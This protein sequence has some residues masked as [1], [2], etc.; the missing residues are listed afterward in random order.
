MKMELNGIKWD[1]TAGF[2]FLIMR[3]SKE[4][5]IKISPEASFH[6]TVKVLLL[7]VFPWSWDLEWD[8]IFF[9]SA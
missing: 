2:K 9:S 1:S 8:E 3:H 5:N 6:W 7:K 4:G